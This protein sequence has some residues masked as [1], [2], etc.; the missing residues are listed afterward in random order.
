MMATLVLTGVGT[1]IGGP[2]GGAVGALLGQAVDARLF[3]PSARQ[4]ARLPTLAVQTSTYGGDIPKLFGRMRV[5]GTVIWSTDLREERSTSGGGK[6]RPKTVDYAYSASFAVLL[7]G[8]RVRS[9]GRI[10]ADGKLLRGAAGDFKTATGF[11]LW[12]GGEDQPVDPLIASVEGAGGTP[13]YRGLAYAVFEDLALADFGNRI[14]SLTF[15][16][17]A[18]EEPVPVPAIAAALSGGGVAGGP[19]AAPAGFAA[20]G[21]SLRGAI[22]PLAEAYGL[23]LCAEPDGLRLVAAADEPEL[24]I[25][26]EDGASSDGGAAR[27]EIRRGRASGVPEE[28][29]LG[30]YDVDRDYQAGLQRATRAGG[31]GSERLALPAALAAADAKGLAAARLGRLTAARETLR[32]RF[33]PRCLSLATGAR[34]RLSG[35]GGHWLIARLSLERLVV[36]AELVRLPAPAE[37]SPPA[38]PGRALAEPDSE[39][40][41]TRLLLF[42]LPADGE[43]P[44][45]PRVFAAAA[46]A[47][48]G[49]RPVPLSASRDGGAS[50]SPA[51]RSGP[52]AV[53][54]TTLTALGPGGGSAAF[55]T[56]SSVEVE[57]LRD[58]AWLESRSD[59]ALAG[60]GNAALVGSEIVQFGEAAPLGGRRFRLARLLR[61]RRGTEWA[62]G[63][64]GAGA[65]FLLLD[66]AALFSLDLTPGSVGGD[67]L[68]A[69]ESP[70]DEGTPPASL[71]VGGEGLRP[72]SPVHLR[73]RRAADGG[74]T[75]S[76]VRR[77]RFGWAWLDG[78]DAPLGEER[79]AYRVTLAA[80]GSQ[81]AWETSEPSLALASPDLAGLDGTLEIEVVQL[82]T[83]AASHPARLVID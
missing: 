64:A 78:A 34:A 68:F 49:W 48:E 79:E 76:W 59:L 8:R 26:A 62:A 74:I 47:G 40:G 46:G 53:I 73:G 45:A 63:G 22:E 19:G 31:R 36:E 56:A 51:G 72:P 32:L 81:R 37:P 29:S 1:L 50:W 71:L 13:A 24:E 75:L 57:L 60:G 21:D 23:T 33:G 7:S 38:A 69:S 54:G 55:D 61:G 43:M 10:W 27:R 44:S 65:P 3:A 42:E 35:V 58:D 16:L 12:T 15:E 52:A 28:V 6:G 70:A 5:A 11:R 17:T 30:Y 80:D 39:R 4:G 66:P 67:I 25:S 9:V 14:P 41:P 83:Y 82:G 77:S 20:G 2:V 18:D